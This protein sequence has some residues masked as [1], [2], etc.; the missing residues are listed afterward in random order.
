VPE[1]I[2]P[3]WPAILRIEFLQP[4]GVKWSSFVRNVDM[5]PNAYQKPEN[6]GGLERTNDVV[7]ANDGKTLYV[8][9]YGELYV[10]YSMPSPFFQTP[11]SSV[12][13]KVTY[14]EHRR[15]SEGRPIHRPGSMR[16]CRQGWRSASPEPARPS[17][18][19]EVPAGAG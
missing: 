5:G 1:S 4:A 11:K 10:D 19:R 3:T 7:F 18:P 9:D 12:I 14:S 6:H 13:W 8:V 17:S 16:R 15:P 2:V